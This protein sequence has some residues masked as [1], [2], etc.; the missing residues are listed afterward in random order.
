VINDQQIGELIRKIRKEKGYTT[1]QLA[2]KLNISQPKLSRIETGAQSI[3]LTLL[4][5]FCDALQISLADF[6]F[7]L[8]DNNHINEMMS[9]RENSP[10]YDDLSNV[11]LTKLLTSLSLEERKAIIQFIQVFKKR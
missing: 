8:E 1:K 9:V 5:Q 6:C 11:S 3:P 10:I 4:Y 2:D 7:L